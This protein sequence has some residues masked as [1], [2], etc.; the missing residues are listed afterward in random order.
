MR[1]K[2]RLA[3]VR[4]KGQAWS[5][6]EPTLHRG[7][8]GPKTQQWLPAALI[9][10][11]GTDRSAIQ[12]SQV[13]VSVSLPCL[14]PPPRRLSFRVL[15]SP[16]SSTADNGESV[17]MAAVSAQRSPAFLCFP[18]PRRLYFRSLARSRPAVVARR[19]GQ[20]GE[21]TANGQTTTAGAIPNTAADLGGIGLV[22]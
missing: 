14:W 19:E 2:A 12:P 6:H 21:W 7:L 20:D 18:S 16:L 4:D 11:G 8:S 13:R 10:R 9:R 3:V 17:P 1:V 5:D 15:L 22:V